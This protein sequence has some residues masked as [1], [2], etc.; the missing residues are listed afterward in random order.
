MKKRLDI[1]KKVIDES[2]NGQES[3]KQSEKL[4]NAILS[5]IK[6]LEQLLRKIKTLFLEGI[7]LAI[8]YKNFHNFC[9]D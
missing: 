6:L 2:W 8:N 7:D 4:E 9:F 5:M 3:F 1:L